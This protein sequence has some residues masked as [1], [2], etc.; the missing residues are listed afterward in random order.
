MKGVAASP[1]PFLSFPFTVLF[2]SL[3]ICL[4]AASTMRLR[5]VLSVLFLRGVF[6]LSSSSTVTRDRQP[7]CLREEKMNRTRAGVCTLHLLA[8]SKLRTMR[9][10]MYNG[11]VA[12]LARRV[13]RQPMKSMKAP[14][15][16][17][18]HNYYKVISIGTVRRRTTTAKP[19]CR[20]G[21]LYPRMDIFIFGPPPLQKMLRPS[22]VTDAVLKVD[23]ALFE[24]WNC[25]W[26][27]TGEPF[28]LPNLGFF[29]RPAQGHGQS[30]QPR[31]GA[32][33]AHT[34]TLADS[35]DK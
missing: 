34:H 11:H 24:V 6:F 5:D 23:H 12:A 13:N 28:P 19:L 21:Q 20:S 32:H 14:G 26:F 30:D 9:M 10:R 35:N 8:I 1:L 27:R 29:L 16:I 33:D 22:F 7:L 18:G 15:P 4:S 25:F 31:E 17:T 3:P 2:H